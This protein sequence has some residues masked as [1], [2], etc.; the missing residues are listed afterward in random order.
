M[1][2]VNKYKYSRKIQ[3]TIFKKGTGMF[4]DKNGKY[5]IFTFALFCDID[6]LIL[7]HDYQLCFDMVDMDMIID[8][9]ED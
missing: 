2:L 5:Y 8:F 7:N 1:I 9:K 3:K 4:K 6:K